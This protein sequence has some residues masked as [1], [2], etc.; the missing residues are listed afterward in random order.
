MTAWTAQAHKTRPSASLLGR[1]MSKYFLYCKISQKCQR[2][3]FGRSPWEKTSSPLLERRGTEGR[4]GSERSEEEDGKEKLERGGE[5]RKRVGA[6]L[7][8]SDMLTHSHAGLPGL[9]LFLQNHSSLSLSFF[10]TL[11]SLGR[12]QEYTMLVVIEIPLTVFI[13]TH[14]RMRSFCMH[15]KHKY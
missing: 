8:L 14:R 11:L 13:C 5:R 3:Q 4:E 7:T 2:K 10:P 6:L 9:F 12:L 15:T 1:N